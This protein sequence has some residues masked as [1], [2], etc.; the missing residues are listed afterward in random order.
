MFDHEATAARYWNN[1][2]TKPPNLF[3]AIRYPM[4]WLSQ[5][6]FWAANV[7]VEEARHTGKNTQLKFTTAG[8]KQVSALEIEN[9]QIF[10]SKLLGW[11]RV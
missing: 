11:Y 3:M 1:Q 6:N 7:V 4:V 10:S 2:H 8:M 9:M 5:L